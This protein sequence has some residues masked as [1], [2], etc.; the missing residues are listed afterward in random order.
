M[1]EGLCCVDEEQ[2]ARTEPRFPA[3]EA[4]PQLTI[5]A[6]TPVSWT[7]SRMLL[8][9]MNSRVPTAGN[10]LNAALFA[11]WNKSKSASSCLMEGRSAS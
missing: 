6:S 8:E 10:C 2:G 4:G 7:C 5:R 1:R 3:N 11:F 9:V